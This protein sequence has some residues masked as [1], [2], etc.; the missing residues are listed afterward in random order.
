MEALWG[1]TYRDLLVS[2]I[3]RLAPGLAELLAAGAR[4][5]DVACGTGDALLAL[6]A[7]YPASRF[8]GYDLDTDAITRACGKADSAGLANVRFEQCDAAELTGVEPF[9]A[10]FVFNA[11]HDQAAPDRVLERIRHALVPGGVLLMDEPRV[12]SNLEDDVGNPLAPSTYAVSTLHC[13]T[14][15]LAVGGAGLGTALGEQVACR[16]LADAGFDNVVVHDAPGNAVFVTRTK[17]V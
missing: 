1:P 9:D 6:A 2:A 15:S 11:L 16:M 3:V 12:S 4:A 17:A 10:V 5:A 7:S 8:V 13:L 14:V